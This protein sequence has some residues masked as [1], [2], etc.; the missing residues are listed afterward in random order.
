MR[1]F[2][3]G[4][5]VR[6]IDTRGYT[7]IE[8]GKTYEVSRRITLDGR[9]YVVLKGIRDNGPNLG[10]WHDGMFELVS[11]AEGYWLS[12]ELWEVAL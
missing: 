4:D 3:K 6:C 2:Q 8:K 12:N 7:L 1:K 11:L 5:M 9:E 10:G